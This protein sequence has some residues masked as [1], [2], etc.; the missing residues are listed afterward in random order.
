MCHPGDPSSPGDSRVTEPSCSAAASP[1]ESVNAQLVAA[2]YKLSHI[3]L[4]PGDSRSRA[5]GFPT[6]RSPSL[7]R[8]VSPKGWVGGQHLQP[9][10]PAAPERWGW[11]CPWPARASPGMAKPGETLARKKRR[12]AGGSRVAP[13][14]ISKPGDFSLQEAARWP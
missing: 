2:R 10:L 6:C 1:A 5:L 3:H 11:S 7:E 8:Q 9:R 13:I 12:E 14:F 4:S